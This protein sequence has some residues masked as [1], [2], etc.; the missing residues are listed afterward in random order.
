[1]T[2]VCAIR[3]VHKGWRIKTGYL[4]EIHKFLITKVENI[5]QMYALMKYQNTKKTTITKFHNI[6][7]N[8]T[9]K[10]S[11]IAKCPLFFNI[12]EGLLLYEHIT[13]P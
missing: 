2:N 1:M 11:Q 10:L 7:I 8:I 5:C 3:F 13:K 6:K 4:I 12:L 9:L